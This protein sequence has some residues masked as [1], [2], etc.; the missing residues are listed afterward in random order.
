MSIRILSIMSLRDDEF[1]SYEF[2][3]IMSMMSVME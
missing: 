1:M 3:S 2:M